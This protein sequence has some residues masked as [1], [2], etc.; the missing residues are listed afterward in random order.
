MY[1][2]GLNN[3]IPEIKKINLHQLCQLQ[4]YQLLW[5][6]L[7]RQ[8][9]LPIKLKACAH[10]YCTWKIWPFYIQTKLLTAIIKNSELLKELSEISISA[11]VFWTFDVCFSA[12][13]L[14]IFCIISY[15]ILTSRSSYCEL[16]NTYVLAT[17]TVMFS[18]A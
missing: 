16:V 12:D 18:S 4:I 5:I 14:Q 6:H 9:F 2:T 3:N 10:F 15:G 8:G 1:K 13:F 17:L 7:N 11:S